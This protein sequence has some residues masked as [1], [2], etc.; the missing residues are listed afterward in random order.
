VP[1]ENSD[2]QAFSIS[3]V[4]AFRQS[5]WFIR[6]WTLQELLAPANVEFFSQEGKLLGSKISLER[7]VCEI[8]KVPVEALR[9]QRLSE[10][11]IDERMSWAAKRTTTLKED[12]V[13]CLLGIFGVYLPLIYG[14]GEAYAELRL[15][16]EIERRRKGQGI[17]RVQDLAGMLNKADVGGTCS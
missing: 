8:T 4:Q 12:K 5:T 14:E 3:W 1:E 2:V 17:E 13:Y 16:E 11:S 6:G 7:E 9:G 15:R 10:F